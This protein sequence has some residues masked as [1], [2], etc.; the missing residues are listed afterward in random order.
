[1]DSAFIKQGCLLL[2][3]TVLF[4]SFIPEARRNKTLEKL[5]QTQIC[6]GKVGYGK[7]KKWSESDLI[8]I[9]FT[10]SKPL[11][12]VRIHLKFFEVFLKDTNYG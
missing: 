10:E 3:V 4:L 2:V 1:M 9:E 5:T 11:L 12:F 6:W 7:K 8:N